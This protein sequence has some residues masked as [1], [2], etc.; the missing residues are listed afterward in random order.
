[1]VLEASLSDLRSQGY[2]VDVGDVVIGPEDE[3]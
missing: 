3:T 2:E 1:M